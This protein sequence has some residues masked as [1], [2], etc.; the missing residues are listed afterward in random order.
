VQFTNLNTTVT[1]QGTTITSQGSSIT[2]LQ[3][4]ITLKVDTTTYNTKMASIDGSITSINTSLSTQSS[5]ITALQNSIVLKVTQTDIN[6]S[7]N[8]IQIGGR[9]LLLG[10][11]VATT[12][13]SYMVKNYTMSMAMVAGTTY[14]ISLK[15]NFA[16]GRNIWVYCNTGYLSLASIPTASGDIVYNICR[17][18][19]K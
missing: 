2:A 4:S 9:N 10:S 1:N 5:S 8:G 3:N 17:Q 15:A 18:D 13:T 14:T 16:T 12:N 11:N 7:I 6:T 19:W